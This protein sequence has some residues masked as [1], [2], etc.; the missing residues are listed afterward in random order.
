MMI[1]VANVRL[2][3][4]FRLVN[5]WMMRARRPLL[6]LAAVTFVSGFF[7]AFLVNDAI[8]LVLTP[9]ILD[10]V[11]RLC[12]NPVPYL[13]AAA[14]A[15]NVGSTATITGD[16]QN[17]LIGSFSQIPYATFSASTSERKGTLE[18]PKSRR[19]KITCRSKNVSRP[20][21]SPTCR[22]I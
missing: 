12:R 7:S 9:L 6:L 16:P 15:S 22:G 11:T 2:S 5:N 20:R 19:R 1:V 4:F 21:C 14:M 13:L 3:G 17:I 18:E 10:C 8:C